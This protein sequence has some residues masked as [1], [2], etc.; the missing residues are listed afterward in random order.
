MGANR[1]VVVGGSL[2]GS[3][4][5]ESV[6]RAGYEGNI[7]LVGAEPERAYDRPPLSKKYLRGQHPEEKLYLRPLEH[8]ERMKIE[9]VLGA[10]AK[11]L[12]TTAR[13]VELEGGRTLDFD[14]LVIA[15]GA[16]VRKL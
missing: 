10:R 12:D 4:A 15:T 3:R 7:A 8:Y 9:L 11:R 16:D 6:R 1:I 5:A 14:Q 13:S 2:A